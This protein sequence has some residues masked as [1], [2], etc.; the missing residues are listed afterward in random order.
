MSVK[1]ADT[2]RDYLNE[3]NKQPL[4]MTQYFLKELLKDND[5]K[6]FYNE[7]NIMTVISKRSK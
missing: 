3:Y 7:E 5:V 1:A 2:I 4:R 6:E